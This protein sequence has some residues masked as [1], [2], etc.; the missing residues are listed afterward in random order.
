MPS[1]NKNV[2]VLDRVSSI[3]LVAYSV[4]QMSTMLAS[5]RYTAT[6]YST[7]KD[8]SVSAYSYA[9]PLQVHL[10]PLLASADSYANKAVDAVQTRYPYPFEAQPEDVSTYVRERSASVTKIVEDTRESANKAIE[11]RITNPAKEAAI[12]ID[13]R[14]TPIVDYI[15][16]TAAKNLNTPVPAETQYQVQRVYELSKNVTGQLYDY[17]A[18]TVLVQRASQT[19]TSITEL[20]QSAGARVDS[21]SNRLIGELDSIRTSL[22]ATGATVQSHT[23][24]ASQELNSTI[25]VLRDILSTPNISV[26]EKVNRVAQEVQWRVQPLLSRMMPQQRRQEMANGNAQ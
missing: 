5:N 18:H 23:A 26:S 24:A 2:S 20:A 4:Q 21:L 14:L 8:L 17:S 1:D 3:P 7:A 9:A 15:E 6:P 10:A 11:T 25:T 19:A 12:G 13:S 16:K 22:V